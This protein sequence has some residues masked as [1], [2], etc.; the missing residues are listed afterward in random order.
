MNC[1]FMPR[2]IRFV[3]REAF[4]RK[5]DAIC[6]E[7]QVNK[8]V[9]TRT[10]IRRMCHNRSGKKGRYLQPHILKISTLATSSNGETLRVEGHLGGPSVGE[11]HRC[12]GGVLAAGR[13]L[14][15]DLAG[16]SF[17]DREGIALLRTLKLAG[18]EVVNCSPFIGLRLAEDRVM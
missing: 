16:V 12:C 14:I 5:E 7:R 11:L 17:I 3:P 15:V 6:I 9:P 10:R 8:C 2:P 1:W 13:E 4:R 18:V